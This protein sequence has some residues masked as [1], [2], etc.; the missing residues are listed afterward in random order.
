MRKIV[1]TVLVVVLLVG[2]AAIADGVLRGQAEERVAAEVQ[3]AI[4]GVTAEPDVTIE[5]FPF[6]TQVLGEHLTSV[7]ITAAEA[8]VDGLRL[9]DVVVR[10]H[11][12]TTAAPYVAKTAEMTALAR[13]DDVQAVLGLEGMELGAREGELVAT[14]DVLGVPLDA[15]MT[16]RPEGRDVV[17]DVTAFE[18][19]G[20]RVESSVLPEDL[21]A[22]LQG[23]RFTISGL[24]E[25]MALTEVL[26][27]DDGVRLAAVGRQLSLSAAG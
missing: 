25:G 8:T 26:L 23:L 12:V 10:L 19:G 1:V 5:G 20:F 7:R 27:T 14:A 16:A 21:T 24:P 18:L 6:L 9:E 22:Q 2:A 17:V 3:Q 11:D 15:V 13:P 4:P